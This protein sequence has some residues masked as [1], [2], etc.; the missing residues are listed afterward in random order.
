MAV[1]HL[2]DSEIQD[3]LDGN[4]SDREILSHL[5]QCRRCQSRVN[6]YRSLF[7]GLAKD[8][9]PP[10]PS[11][12][13]AK[14]MNKIT[15]EEKLSRDFPWAF[16][17]V[18][19]GLLAGL[20]SVIVFVNPAVFSRLFSPTGVTGYLDRILFSK[21]N[22]ILSAFNMDTPL[23]VFVVLALLIIGG[24]DFIVRR[25]KHKAVSFIF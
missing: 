5:N 25:I 13:S 17:L 12:F 2:S 21:I 16:L 24:L 9:I 19:A 11:G 20:I 6:Q 14:V 8:R 23:P 7:A 4:I 1:R 15:A 3:Y 22:V 10:L 18:A